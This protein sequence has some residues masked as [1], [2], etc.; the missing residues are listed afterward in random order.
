MGHEEPNL[1]L[2]IINYELYAPIFCF[3]LSDVYLTYLKIESF[4]QMMST[5]VSSFENVIFMLYPF[6]VIFLCYT[7]LV[8]RIRV[9]GISLDF[10]NCIKSLSRICRPIYVPET[11]LEGRLWH[12]LN[13]QSY[14]RKYSNL[15]LIRSLWITHNSLHNC[16]LPSMRILESIRL[17]IYNFE[18][19][20][21]R[22]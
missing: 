11:Y 14:H 2:L 18:P 22:V 19:N 15:K 20:K 17:K 3:F 13:S 6:Y 9:I 5:H 21:F 8:Y 1:L 7:P 4:D 10:I 12:P 16:T